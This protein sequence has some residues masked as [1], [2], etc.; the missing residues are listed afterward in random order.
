MGVEMSLL[1]ILFIKERRI[2]YPTIEPEFPKKPKR[3]VTKVVSGYPLLIAKS[4]EK[5]ID[6]RR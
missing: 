5:E 1:S 6:I 2:H 4:V 3:N